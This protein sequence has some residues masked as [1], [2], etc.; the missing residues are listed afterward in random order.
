MSRLG[1]LFKCPKPTEARAMERSLLVDVCRI[2][3]I[4]VCRRARGAAPLVTPNT[5][6]VAYANPEICRSNGPSRFRRL[7]G[8]GI[9][10]NSGPAPVNASAVDATR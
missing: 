7:S 6:P 2:A 10:G 3:W 4:S 9:A 1:R 8:T 5:G